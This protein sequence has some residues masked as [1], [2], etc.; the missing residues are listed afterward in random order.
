MKNNKPPHKSIFSDLFLKDKVLHFGYLPRWIIFS[1]D[2]FIVIFANIVTYFLISQLTFKYYNTL[3]LTGR[4]MIILATQSFFFFAF[5]TYAGIIRHSTLNDGYNLFKATF[6]SFLA[7]S[8]LNYVHFYKAGA[9]IF[10]MP[11]LLLTFLFSFIFLLFFRIVVKVVY[12]I[13]LDAG[14]QNNLENIVIYG[15]D[16]NAISLANAI[17]AEYPKRYKLVGFADNSKKNVTKQILGLPIYHHNQNVK[18]NFR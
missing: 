16:S 1:I 18:N 15:T 8:A 5:K 12:Q 13:Y 7:L 3:D 6:S 9:K 14:N 2:I 17:N 11:A 4:T 10:L